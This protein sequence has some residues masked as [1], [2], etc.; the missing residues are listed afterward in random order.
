MSRSEED[1]ALLE[2]STGFLIPDLATATMT[3]HAGHVAR[4]N[5]C[6]SFDRLERATL[7]LPPSWLPPGLSHDA[8]ATTLEGN[9]LQSSP[10]WP[11][12]Q[13]APLGEFSVTEAPKWWSHGHVHALVGGAFW[14]TMS[15]WEIAHMARLSEAVA[16]WHWYW[17]SELDQRYCDVHSVMTADQT[18]DCDACRALARSA[19]D[20][21]VRQKRLAAPEARAIA[22]NGL[23]FLRYEAH[24]YTHGLTQGELV[25]PDGPYLNMGEACDYARMH[26]QRLMSPAH[27]RWLDTCRG[28]PIALL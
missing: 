2:A 9:R 20:A 25:I 5:G 26:G 17:L 6:F 19:S 11:F 7:P 15:E 13:D 3:A 27:R 28:D 16:A 12:R 14:P 18:P 22:D 1:D 23:S 10:C 21:S 4:V 24:C 8:F